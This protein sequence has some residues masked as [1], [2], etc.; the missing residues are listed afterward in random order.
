MAPELYDA[1]VQEDVT[2]DKTVVLQ[3]PVLTPPLPNYDPPDGDYI[4]TTRTW[5]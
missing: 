4:D 3:G 2:V 1:A 5:V